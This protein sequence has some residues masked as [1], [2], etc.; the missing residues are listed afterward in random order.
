VKRPV[1]VD[2]EVVQSRTVRTLVGGQ[3]MGGLGVASGVAVGALLAANV[4][5]RP[6]LAG[7]VQSA[8]VL[9]SALLAL[10]AASLAVRFGRR[11]GLGLALAVAAFG[12]LVA[13]LGAELRYFPLLLVGMALF[14]G[15]TT[16]GLQGRY[17]AIDLAEP[18]R[19]G[20]TL[21]VVVW[22]TTIGAVT[23]PNLIGPGG[24]LGEWL[25]IEPLAGPLL[26][27]SAGLVAAAAIVWFGL[28]PDP[29]LLARRLAAVAPETE[30]V[31]VPGVAAVPDRAAGA[32]SALQAD[33]VSAVDAVGPT[34]GTADAVPAAG[35]LGRADAAPRRRRGKLRAGLYA[36]R[37]SP[38]AMLGLAAVVVAHTVMVSVMVMTPIHM[39]HGH[40]SLTVI[41]LVISIHIA[42][43]FAFSPVMG[44]LADRLGRIPVI[45]A[46]GL[47]LL[48]AVALSGTAPEGHSSGLTA[49]LFLLGVGWSACLVAGS[50]LLSESVPVEERPVVQGASDL[51]MGLAA[52]GGGAVAGVVVGRVGYG[53]L[54][55]GAAALVVSLLV[56]VVR[57][58]AAR[59]AA[60]D[61]GSAA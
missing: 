42:G 59:G 54:N 40:A 32:D 48:S 60:A 5:G 8:Q 30:T 23:G 28:R 18:Q 19:R 47:L 33:G 45:G 7:L 1:E 31:A 11:A 53:V 3:V 15:G 36:A 2:V 38:R 24:R 4:L 10:P 12:G 34:D 55:A 6:D 35:D 22:A 49:G 44:W 29:L 27:G 46:G 17:A 37:Q 39:D 61:A 26:I 57:M 51:L 25:G 13:V 14:G 58:A 20:R 52:A 56:L 16:A 50:T 21:S 43:M 9:G 41:G